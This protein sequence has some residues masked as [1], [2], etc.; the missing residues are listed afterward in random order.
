MGFPAYGNGR[1]QPGSDVQV[2]REWKLVFTGRSRGL[3]NPVNSLSE[4]DFSSIS[5]GRNLPGLGTRV[6]RNGEDH[7]PG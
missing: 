6:D 4:L 5:L 2:A 7:P 3:K 1:E